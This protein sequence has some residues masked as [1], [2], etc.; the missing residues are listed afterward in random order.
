MEEEVEGHVRP[1]LLCQEDK[2]DRRNEARLPEI[3]HSEQ[4]VEECFHGLHTKL[5]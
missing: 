5:S 4:I 1:S 3:A 2:I